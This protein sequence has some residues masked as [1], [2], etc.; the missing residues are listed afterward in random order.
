MPDQTTF[1]WFVPS[2]YG[3]EDP[4]APLSNRVM[5]RIDLALMLVVVVCVVWNMLGLRGVRSVTMTMAEA[6]AF[7]LRP[8]TIALWIAVGVSLAWL[9]G[10]FVMTTET[11]FVLFYEGAILFIAILTPM[12]TQEISGF[13]IRR[14]P[15][16]L[17]L[18]ALACPGAPPAAGSTMDRSDCR[19]FQIDES[20][21]AL[22]ASDPRDNADQDLIR[23]VE[24]T[25]NTARWRDLSTGEYTAFMTIDA[26][27]VT[28][29]DGVANVQAFGSGVESACDGDDVFL[30]VRDPNGM[31][32]MQIAIYEDA[33][34]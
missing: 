10:R 31:R 28:C 24:I 14:G 11:R 5:N 16:E 3:D 4:A 8:S 26:P 12:V 1:D 21:F 22:V 29:T 33:R 7:F 2:P 9:I 19:G 32:N 20:M 23:P 18:I 27:G 15:G 17:N 25:G 13:S 34:E 6:Q 30:V